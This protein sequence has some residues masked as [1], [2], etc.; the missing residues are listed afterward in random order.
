MDCSFGFYS[1]CKYYKITFTLLYK[2]NASIYK[3]TAI[4]ATL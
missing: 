4:Q 3:I 2:F 1:L